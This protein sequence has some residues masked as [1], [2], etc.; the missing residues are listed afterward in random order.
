MKVYKK[1]QT[2]DSEDNHDS[3]YIMI[4]IISIA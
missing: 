4:I 3:Y 1:E 2:N